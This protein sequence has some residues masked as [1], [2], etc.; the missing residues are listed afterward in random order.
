MSLFKIGNKKPKKQII[1]FAL[2]LVVNLAASLYFG[3]YILW[4]SFIFFTLI[5]LIDLAYLFIYIR[6]PVIL[7]KINIRST[8]CYS[9]VYLNVTVESNRRCYRCYSIK[10]NGKTNYYNFYE[11]SFAIEL[12]QDKIGEKQI[13]VHSVYSKSVFGIFYRKQLVNDI[14]NKALAC[15]VVPIVRTLTLIDVFK[16]DINTV[17]L[18][19]PLHK[20]ELGDLVG[21]REYTPGDPLNLIN[22]K[23]SATM[24]KAVVRE[25]ARTQPGFNYNIFLDY[26]TNDA[27]EVVA[28]A[29]LAVEEFYTNYG[30]EATHL[31]FYDGYEVSFIKDN[32][33]S[34]P[35]ELALHIGGDIIITEASKVIATGLPTVLILSK[36]RADADVS[37]INNLADF[38]MI[39]LVDEGVKYYEKIANTLKNNG[40][41][42]VII[43]DE[44]MLCEIKNQE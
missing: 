28:E 2:L 13:T 15:L 44:S 36:Y 32:N 27:R 20:Y 19:T 23:K 39:F 16:N 33:M 12:L 21:N 40:S 6:K 22:Y 5:M 4:I 9:K 29:A 41:V 25:H 3:N 1:P 37:Y 26:Y 8:E 18:D 7:Q 30:K 24:N 42:N 10:L 11:N 14:N 31:Y 17:S 35:S 38:S 43:A 34:M